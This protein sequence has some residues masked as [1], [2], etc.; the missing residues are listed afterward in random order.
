II[1]AAS[2]L[3][4]SGTLTAGGQTI[5]K[6]NA[7][8]LEVNNLRAAGLVVNARTVRV[9][10]NGAAAGTSKLGTLTVN[11]GG[12][13][14]LKDNHLVV[15]NGPV[16]SATGGVYNGISGLIQSG[17]NGGAPGAGNWGGSTGIIT[18]MT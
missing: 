17:R 1:P 8:T 7:G 2:V 18:S 9:L 4:V 3:T 12:K 15:T 14:D 13:V 16:G 6:E 10:Q 11:T 5:T